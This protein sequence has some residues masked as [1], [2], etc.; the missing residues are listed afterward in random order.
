MPKKPDENRHMV[1]CS[2]RNIYE[3]CLR[4]IQFNGWKESGTS[5][6]GKGG[7]LC[8][9]NHI[10]REAFSWFIKQKYRYFATKCCFKGFIVAKFHI[11]LMG[12]SMGMLK[13]E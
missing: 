10:L 9:I 12:L 3:I 1:S 4:G 6:N 2:R 5:F 7:L 11:F 8:K 13:T